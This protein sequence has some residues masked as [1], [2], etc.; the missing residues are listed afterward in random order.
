[1]R[2]DVCRTHAARFPKWEFSWEFD[3]G[4]LTSDRPQRLMGI[5]VAD[6]TRTHDDRNH[7]PVH[8]AISTKDLRT[9]FGNALSEMAIDYMAFFFVRSQEIST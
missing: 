9:V 2:F 6:G 8:Q 7:N 3:T 1:M 4:N 5:G